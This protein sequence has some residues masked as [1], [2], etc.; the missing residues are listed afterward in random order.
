MAN[1]IEI[2][3]RLDA[4]GAHLKTTCKIE[5]TSALPQ[6]RWRPNEAHTAKRFE[7]KEECSE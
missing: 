2:N 3:F 4:G 7:S 5:K 6:P 1:D